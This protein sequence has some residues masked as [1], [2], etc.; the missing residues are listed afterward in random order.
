MKVFAPPPMTSTAD[1]AVLH[2]EGQASA[3][4]ALILHGLGYASWAATD[5][6]E[7]LAPHVGLW[8]LDHRGTGRSSRGV[9]PISIGQLAADAVRVLEQ[10]GTTV[11]V[12]GYSMGGYVAQLLAL[13]RPDLVSGLVLIATSAGGVTAT[14]VPAPTAAAWAEAADL[15][16][17]EYAARTMPLSFR[18]GWPDAHADHYQRVLDARLHHPTMQ[19]VW[20]EQYSACEHFLGTGYDPSSLAI[21]VLILHGTDDRVVPVENGRALRRLLPQSRYHEVDHAGHLL[22]IE[23]ADLVASDILQ[24]LFATHHPNTKE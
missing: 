14:P 5:L 17:D 4:P 9:A 22:H 19:S 3:H 13:T 21:P 16:P 2:L 11:P 15:Q 24:F 12:I 20:R 7:H 6:R 10:I 8:S 23:Q 1:G 18:V